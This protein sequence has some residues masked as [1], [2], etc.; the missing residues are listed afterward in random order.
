MAPVD[1]PEPFE[2]VVPVMGTA[3]E[4][5][6][7]PATTCTPDERA[8]ADDEAKDLVVMTRFSIGGS[9]AAWETDHV[10][11]NVGHDTLVYVVV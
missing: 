6:D 4:L 1:R 11:S 5:D 8:G 9:V 3:V 2:L 10:E 7:R